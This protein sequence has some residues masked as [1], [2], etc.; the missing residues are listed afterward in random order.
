MQARHAE[1]RRCA[2]PQP[3]IFDTKRLCFKETYGTVG[4]LS[5][6]QTMISG[7]Q[8]RGVDSSLSGVQAVISLLLE[9]VPK[10]YVGRR[11]GPRS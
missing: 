10:P 6:S 2:G 3:C 1:R 11:F 7:C 5:S 9:A 4:R 8:V